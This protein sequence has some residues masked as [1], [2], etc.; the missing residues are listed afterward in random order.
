MLAAAI[1]LV[2]G[3]TVVTLSEPAGV[4]APLAKGKWEGLWL[5]RLFGPAIVRVDDAATGRMT[6]CILKDSSEVPARLPT[7]LHC[8]ASQV[9]KVENGLVLNLAADELL[10]LARHESALALKGRWL[11]FLL[12][13][14]GE[15][16]ILWRFTGEEATKLVAS[17]ALKGKVLDKDAFGGDVHIDQLESELLKRWISTGAK[18]FDWARPLIFDYYQ[19][20]LMNQ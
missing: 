1:L 15:Q 20:N 19:L 3:C 16:V 17:G 18:E 6:I 10:H 13:H 8:F 14:D 2:A 5:S 9:R 12:R 4:E 11:P 7:Q